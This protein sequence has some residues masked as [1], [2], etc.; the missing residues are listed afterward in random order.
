MR[1]AAVFCGFLP[2]GIAQNKIRFFIKKLVL[3]AYSRCPCR[4][5]RRPK[6]FKNLLGLDGLA[7]AFANHRDDINVIL[8]DDAGFRALIC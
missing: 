7:M 6:A 5:G 8:E 3:G 1:K 4:A 2:S